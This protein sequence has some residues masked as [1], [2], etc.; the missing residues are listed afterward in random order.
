MEGDVLITNSPEKIEAFLKE[1]C[2]ILIYNRHPKVCDLAKILE[3]K[4]EYGFK[5]VVDVDDYWLL[6][7]SHIAYPDWIHY[8]ISEKITAS[9]EAADLVLCTHDRLKVAIN[10]IN[11]NVEIL[12]NAI[13][14]TGQFDIQTMPG[15]RTRIFWAGSITHLR[16]IEIL[17]NPFK[18]L[19]SS[20]L[21]DKVMVVMGGFMPNQPHWGEMAS[22]YTCGMRLK[23]AVLEGLPTEKYYSLYQYADITV[24][25]LRDSLFNGYKSNLK[26]LEAAN[27]G[28]PC[29]VSRV[30]PYLNLPVSYVDRQGD[31]FDHIKRLT[32]NPEQ[33][34]KE[35][36]ALKDYC[37]LHYNFE[38]IN[39][40]RFQM[41]GQICGKY[42]YQYAE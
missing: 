7:P 33:R 11:P 30:N 4:A 21:C 42:I 34:T 1:G 5:L 20:E 2:D 13:P 19:Q 16:D 36:Q 24:I 39:R 31:W 26:V 6:D 29:I 35:G 3:W 37:D 41:F 18:R 10:S 28:S 32:N 38:K 17:R 27:V 9:I 22:I 15:R 25:P 8:G 23:G 14:K 12:P 40:T